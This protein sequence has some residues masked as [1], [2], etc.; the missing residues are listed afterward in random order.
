M[1]RR[2]YIVSYDIS[3]DKRRTE[4]YELLL[5]Y[6]DHVQ[7]SVFLCELNAVE[8]SGLRRRLR[9]AIHAREDQVLI[10]DL[11]PAT[12]SLEASIVA[13][14]RPYEPQVRTIVV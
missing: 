5:G 2:H 9:D 12:S 3:D 14:G 10:I 13:I 6:G 7:Y 11:G 4:V 1:A 8:L